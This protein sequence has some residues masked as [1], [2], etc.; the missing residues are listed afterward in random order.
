M[1]RNNAVNSYVS[2]IGRLSARDNPFADEDVTSPEPEKENKS[3]AYVRP[4]F[5]AYIAAAVLTVCIGA[6]AVF[7][8]GHLKK[9]ETPADSI[10]SSAVPDDSILTS[11]SDPTLPAPG[12]ITLTKTFTDTET[13]MEKY[14]EA[15]KASHEL[16]RYYDSAIASGKDSDALKKSVSDMIYPYAE[17]CQA[18]VSFLEETNSSM[19]CYLLEVVKYE[20]EDTLSLYVINKT[21]SEIALTG[22]GRAHRNQTGEKLCDLTFS[23]IRLPPDELSVIKLPS[24]GII[25]DDFNVVLETPDGSTLSV[26]AEPGTIIRALNRERISELSRKLSEK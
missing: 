3:A 18:A 17:V 4:R 7:A 25:T 2:G 11:D 24:D 5:G 8:L 9:D 13:A 15:E 16:L 26:S 1:R 22:S 19:S 23:Q 6:G 21:G 14:R 20:G 12:D 10:A